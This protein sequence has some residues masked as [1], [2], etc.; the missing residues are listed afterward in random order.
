MYVLSSVE[1][2]GFIGAGRPIKWLTNSLIV[3]NTSDSR[4]SR[5]KLLISRLETGLRRLISIRLGAE[6]GAN[7]WTSVPAQIQ[8]SSARAMRGAG[9]GDPID[10]T[11]LPQ[12]RTIVV[13]FW[14]SFQDV[15]ANQPQFE[16]TMDDLNEIRRTESHNREISNAQIL[17]LDAIYEDLAGKMVGEEGTTVPE[18]LVENWRARLAEI[19]QQVSDRCLI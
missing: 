14:N 11:Y 7:W 17:S 18:F 2:A 9:P 8:K 6:L 5:A 1:V 4:R 10:F 16:T 13:G 15:F 12:L 19:V 3:V